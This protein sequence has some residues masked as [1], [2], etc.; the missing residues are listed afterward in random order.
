MAQPLLSVL[1]YR[2]SELYRPTAD[3]PDELVRGRKR[4]AQE[5]HDGRVH[6][7]IVNEGRFCGNERAPSDDIAISLACPSHFL[8]SCLLPICQRC[9]QCLSSATYA[10][11]KGVHKK[12]K[13][14]TTENLF[15]ATRFYQEEEMQTRHRQNSLLDFF[16]LPPRVVTHQSH[17]FK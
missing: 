14:P 8:F 5:G 1:V 2:E 3:T 4:K 12:L 13:N 7:K 10:K 15:E 16:P 9:A 11:E 6:A 17:V